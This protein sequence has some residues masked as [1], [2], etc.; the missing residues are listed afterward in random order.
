MGTDLRASAGE[1]LAWRRARG[2]RLSRHDGLIGQFLDHLEHR[3]VSRISVEDAL[4]WACLP[5]GARPRW[6]SARLAAI[7]GFA[8][9]VHAH[10]VEAAELIPTG[11]VPS[12]VERAVPYLYTPAQITGL[13]NHAHTLAPAVR[14]ITLATVIG[15]MA[16]TG[17]RIGEAL[18]L[19]T[20]SLDLG[21][22]TIIVTGKYGNTRRLPVHS[23]TTTALAGYLRTSRYLVGSPH[24]QALFVTVNATRPRARN[25]QQAFRALTRACRLPVGTANNE[26][27]LHDLRHSF[28]VNTLIE[29]HRAGV[30]VDARIAALATYLGHTSPTSTYWYLTASPQLLDLVNDRVEAYRQGRTS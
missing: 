13:I 23:S 1:Y 5:R 9:H 17:L 14:G 25:I 24:D 16:A 8:A 26:P 21:R 30:D 12:R 15:L 27:R 19:D 11:L 2:Y 6:H 18:A 7:R 10:H 29:A 4:A 20:T 22:G 3:Q 28:A